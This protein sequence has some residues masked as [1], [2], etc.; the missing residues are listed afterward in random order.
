MSRTHTLTVLLLFITSFSFA[1]TY[2]NEWINFTGNNTYSS[3]QYYKIKVVKEGIYRISYNTL[4]ASGASTILGQNPR[5]IQLFFQG[6]EQPIYIEGEGDGT[7]DA[8]DFIE[9]YGKPNDGKLDQGLYINGTTGNADPNA[10]LHPNYSLFT[11]TAVYFLTWRVD[12]SMGLRV[13]QPND[14]NFSTHTAFPY[15]FRQDIMQGTEWYY[16]GPTNGTSGYKTTDPDYVDGEG[17]TKPYFQVSTQNGSSNQSYTFQIPNFYSLN[18]GLSPTF[19]VT[20]ISQSNYAG[21]SPNHH[22]S[23]K[24]NNIQKINT[25]YN[26]FALSHFNFNITAAELGLSQT[27]NLLFEAILPSGAP[28]SYTDADAAANIRLTY[29]HTQSLNNEASPV[30]YSM[31]IPGDASGEAFLNLTGFGLANGA[32]VLYNKTNWSRI[33]TVIQ[34]SKVR[35]LIP[36][37][38]SDTSKCY[39]SSDFQNVLPSAIQP[40]RE[41]FSPN[42]RF[43]NFKAAPLNSP[44]IIISHRSLWPEA[45]NYSNYRSS[46]AGGSFQVVLADIDELYDQFAWGI[47]KH[48]LSIR[49]FCDFA[50]HQW[51]KK[52]QYL[53]LLGKAIFADIDSRYSTAQFAMN[54]IPTM[55]F[56]P[57]DNLFTSR[58]NGTNYLPEIPTG[59]LAASSLLEVSEYL[60]KVQDYETAQHTPAEW[61]KQVLHFGGGSDANEQSVF[62]SYLNNFKNIIEGPYFGGHVTS[63][64]KTSSDPIQVNLSHALQAQIDSGVSIM[65]FFGHAAAATG[66]DNSTDQP[67]NYNNYKRYPLVIANSCFAGDI[68]QPT[69]SVSEGFILLPDKGAIAFLASVALGQE[70]FLNEYTTSLYDNISNS[71]Y[72]HS[73]GSHMHNVIQ[74]TYQADP[75]SYFRKSTCLEMTLHG[76]PALVINSFPKPD[77]VITPP[78][79]YFSPNP[80]TAEMDSFDVHVIITNI[81]R[82][83]TQH[84][85]VSVRRDFPTGIHSDTTFRRPFPPSTSTNYQDIITFRVPLDPFNGFGLNTFTVVLDT[86]NEMDEMN[87]SN[88]TASTT[89]MIK[90]DDIVPVFP[91]NFAIIP[92][93][94][95]TLKACTSDPFAVSR[96][97]EFQIDTTD[98]YN[99]PMLRKTHI[100]QTGGVV[101]WQ[102]PYPYLKDSMVYYWK[103][104]VDSAT[105][106]SYRWREFSFIYIPTKTGW[107]QAHIWQFKNDDYHNVLYSRPNRDFEFVT[108]LGALDVKNMLNPFSPP[109]PQPAGLIGY[110]INNT[111]GDYGACT[112]NPSIHVAVIDSLTFNTW[113][114]GDHYFGNVNTYDQITHTG[115]CRDR[116]E[117][118]FIFRAGDQAQMNSMVSMLQNDV[119][120]GDYILI[121]SVFDIPYTSYSWMGAV[122]AELQLLGFTNAPLLQDHQAF[123]FATQKCHPDSS[124]IVL[125]SVGGYSQQLSMSVSLMNNW[126]VGDIYSPKIGPAS[127]WTELHWREHSI[128]PFYSE[129]TIY[130]DV[131]G[132]HMD[133]S[134]TTLVSHLPVTSPTYDLSGIIASSGNATTDYPYLKLHAYV[135]DKKLRT[136]PQLNK[137]QI[138]YDGVPD[139]AINPSKGWSFYGNS[140]DEGDTLRFSTHIENISSYPM[141]DSLLVKSWFYDTGRNRHDIGSVKKKIM[142][143][144]DTISVAFSSP[145]LGSAGLNSFWIEANPLL[146]PIEQYHFNNLGNLNFTTKADIT[147][148]ILDVTF[149]GV[150]ILDGDIVSAKPAVIIKLKDENKFLAL[151]DTQLFR[152]YLTNPENIRTQLSFSQPAQNGYRISWF[153]AVMP[154]NSFRIEYFPTLEDG[155]YKLEIDGHD[156]AGNN[157]GDFKYM[158]SF[159]V[160]NKPS[161]TYVMN[162]PNPFSTS[163]RFVFTLTGTEIPEYFKIQIITISGKVVREITE[164]ELGP[165][166]IGR[167]IS[168]YAWD[169]KDTYGD[170]LANGVYFYRTVTRLHGQVIE[171]RKTDVDHAFKHDWGK[172]YLL[173]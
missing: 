7:F 44:Y 146:N 63:Y 74:S 86:G 121:F 76:D 156:K 43:T 53:L 92:D 71:N 166:H 160:V 117:N 163:T 134:S 122:K 144:G 99:S 158:I 77:L 31:I 107:S 131:F 24:V 173:R 113:T 47:Q 157:S 42:D 60:R 37:I 172:M 141:P 126:N 95:V 12:A 14:T 25:T 145:T 10:Q 90:A 149:D 3:Q 138:Y 35:A 152:L 64:Y 154:N 100:T 70:V 97:Y 104:S 114:T 22:F 150:H 23:I 1:Q 98:L 169:G 133:G 151:N 6:A 55:G 96:D 147:N 112:P 15:F 132:Y 83:D 153:P 93:N 115:V 167:N 38:I 18:P 165:L 110:T 46:S 116:P 11:D 9:F 27:C 82:T 50:L 123:I 33:Q 58:I 39:I 136:P 85:T 41:G 78:N 79:I 162:Y 32:P 91:I 88:N 20:T 5:K 49:N 105:Y 109:Y 89:L 52:P 26:G 125:S 102:N 29:P 120:C 73:I 130:L 34:T 161:I 17:Y 140:L 68:H 111:G 30:S 94:H 81:A 61:M 171:Q 13:T 106:G 69:P 139:V 101:N 135:Q 168:E 19:D 119:P 170:Q 4:L 124:H 127:H 16:Y 108:N 84:Y 40:V 118:Y 36:G 65:T 164:N 148:P 62:Q 8:S 66:F 59:R 159:E 21:L 51:L 48:P 103:V 143:S 57:C 45:I 142:L 56:P 2:G 67:S 80:V 28:Q 87:E 137:W 72:G 155:I 75:N 129:D 54:L 128:E